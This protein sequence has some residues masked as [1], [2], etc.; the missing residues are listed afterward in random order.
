M[1]PSM[2]PPQ[3]SEQAVLQLARKHPLLRARDIAREGLPTI[4]LTRLVSAG[5]LERVARGVYSL[6]NR[7]ISENRSLAEVAIQV[8]RGVICLVS[9]LRVHHIGTQAPHEVWLAI[10][11]RMLSPRIE[12]PALRV[13]RMS[14]P[15]LTE[16]IDRRTVDGVEVP[17]FNAA[18][19]IADCFKY[20]NK[21]GLDVALEALRESWNKRKV[22]MDDL[23]RY[24]A[25][26]RVANVM[27]PYLETIAAS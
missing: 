21:I 24:A 25:V 7:A 27:R 18:K 13:I 23:W 20:R 5:K 6:P 22:T 14:G 10:P 11:H 4:A 9:A 3:T 16:G 2:P 17:V 26:D 12:K 15:S 8:P 1:L 19:T